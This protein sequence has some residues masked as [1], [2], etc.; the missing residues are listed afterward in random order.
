MFDNLTADE[1]MALYAD[2]LRRNSQAT[3]PVPGVPIEIR[4][5]NLLP[6]G[7]VAVVSGDKIILINGVMA[8]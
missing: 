4:T 8:P 1:V 5:S 7:T 2:L 6:V 3:A